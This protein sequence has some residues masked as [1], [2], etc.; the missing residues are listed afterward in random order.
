MPA[1]GNAYF[2]A[3]VCNHNSHTFSSPAVDNMIYHYKL[4]FR[5]CLPSKGPLGVICHA[6][7]IVPRL[8]LGVSW[9]LA[10][11]KC[12]SCQDDE[13]S[14]WQPVRSECAVGPASASEPGNQVRTH[15][16]HELLRTSTDILR[17]PLFLRLCSDTTSVRGGMYASRSMPTASDAARMATYRC[18]ASRSFSAP[19]PWITS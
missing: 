2:F 17:M 16:E 6:K 13:V 19:M 11:G 9:P 8:V 5:R 14:V 7:S 10:P 3:L 4:S 12:N 1:H 18:S 15:S